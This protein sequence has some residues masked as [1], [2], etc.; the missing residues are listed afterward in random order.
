MGVANAQA[1]VAHTHP[2]TQGLLR[3]AIPPFPARIPPNQ[4]PCSLPDQDWLSGKLHFVK[5]F[6]AAAAASAATVACLAPGT[7]GIGGLVCSQNHN[8]GLPSGSQHLRAVF[9]D[10]NRRSSVASA[11]CLPC[12]GCSGP[13]ALLLRTFRNRT[14]LRLIKNITLHPIGFSAGK[15]GFSRRENSDTNALQVRL[16]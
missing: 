13:L 6:A 7:V 11:H 9:V 8:D 5:C 15:E 3:G 2:H 4:V 14:G 16:D 1:L 12:S 10:H